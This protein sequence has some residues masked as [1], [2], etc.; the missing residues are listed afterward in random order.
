MMFG[1]FA[2]HPQRIQDMLHISDEEKANIADGCLKTLRLEQL[3]ISRRMQ[4]MYRFEKSMYADP[5]Q[6]LNTLRRNLVEKYQMMKRPEGRNEPDRASKIHI[7]CYP[8]YY[9]N[10]Q[11]G[12]LLASQLY[13]HIAKN[14]LNTSDVHAQSFFNKPEV[15]EYLK[16]NIFTPGCK[17]RWDTMIELATGEGLS[18]KRY[19]KQ[20]VE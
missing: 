1:R 6:D 11:L 16:K 3:V 5:N 12:E 19:A 9:H 10:Y 20:F 4:V 8:C 7:A 14:V 17:Y 18:P 15:G 13:Y 2:S